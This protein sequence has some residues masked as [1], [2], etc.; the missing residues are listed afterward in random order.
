MG[1]LR[2]GLLKCIKEV[3]KHPR[4]PIGICRGSQSWHSTMSFDEYEGKNDIEDDSFIDD[5]RELEPQGVDP[6]KGWG[7][8]GVHK[9]II[10]G[11]IG[12]TPVQK[13][14]RNG[15]TVTI[16]TVGTGGMYDQ[17]IIGAEQLPRPAQWHRIVVHNEQLGAYSVQQLVKDSA[18]FIE[19]DI[20]TRV[21]NDSINGQVKNVPEICV[22]RDGKVRLVKSGD[23]AANI[24]LDELREGLF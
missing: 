17:R 20:E 18:V 8:R 7:F 15:R 14:L 22:R 6:K 19:G 16:F 5:N 9:A 23:S 21:Y 12:Q 10:C 3:S 1:S 2:G 24:S 13:I 4:F 11:K